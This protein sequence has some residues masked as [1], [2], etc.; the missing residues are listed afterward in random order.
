MT[1][2]TKAL[3]N[4]MIIGSSHVEWI[5]TAML[6]LSSKLRAQASLRTRSCVIL[7]HKL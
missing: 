1:A 6:M 2:E 7:Q 3:H 5:C 4:G